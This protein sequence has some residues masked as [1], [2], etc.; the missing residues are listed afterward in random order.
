LPPYRRLQPLSFAP[1]SRDSRTDLWHWDQPFFL[2]TQKFGVAN[3]PRRKRPST[4]PTFVRP[5]AAVPAPF[6]HR[7]RDLAHQAGK[8]LDLVL[9][10]VLDRLLAD[11][12]D[13]QGFQLRQRR[14]KWD[15][16]RSSMHFSSAG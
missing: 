6:A 3:H 7:K 10:S 8:L 11:Q 13:E 4:R 15:L 9:N 2:V 14:K 12:H 16:P 5:D 1:P